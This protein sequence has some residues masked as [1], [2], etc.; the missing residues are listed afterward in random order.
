LMNTG[1]RRTGKHFLAELENKDPVAE[2]LQLLREEQAMRAQERR[3]NYQVVLFWLIVLMLA[4]SFGWIKLP[5]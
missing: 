4:A 1:P 5:F 3:D 2:Q